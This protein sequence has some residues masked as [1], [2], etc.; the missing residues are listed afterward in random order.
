MMIKLKFRV[1]LTAMTTIF[2]AFAICGQTVD[3]CQTQKD[4]S[5]N[6]LRSFQAPIPADQVQPQQLEIE[7]APDAGFDAAANRPVSAVPG[8]IYSLLE[9]VSGPDSLLEQ[10]KPAVHV[11]EDCGELSELPTPAEAAN[12][13]AAGLFFDRQVRPA[14]HNGLATEATGEGHVPFGGPASLD[15]P[16]SVRKI[17]MATAI[18]MFGCVL[19]VLGAKFFRRSGTPAKTETVAARVEQIIQLGNKSTLRLVRIGRQQVLVAADSS[20]IRSVT[21][22]QPDFESLIEEDKT[23]ES[24]ANDFQAALAG[25]FQSMK[26][27]RSQG[28]V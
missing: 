10:E 11:A 5:G 4:S 19:F 18:S 12:S 28:T 14:S 21:A 13:G 2:A 7:P 27:D 1:F 24:E 6:P 26:N 9:P 15:I 25:Y 22:V 3:G 16:D 8:G 17:A 20:G 23:V